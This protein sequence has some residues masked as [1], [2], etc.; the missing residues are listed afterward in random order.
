MPITAPATARPTVP[1][2][3]TTAT[4]VRLLVITSA[5]TSH[6]PTPGRPQ[7]SAWESKHAVCAPRGEILASFN[8]PRHKLRV[9]RAA[10]AAATAA[11]SQV[12]SGASAARGRGVLHA[13]CRRPARAAT[14]FLDRGS[15]TPLWR[16]QLVATP[17]RRCYGCRFWAHGDSGEGPMLRHCVPP[18]RHHPTSPKHS[19]R[20]TRRTS[21]AARSG[22][23]APAAARWRRPGHHPLPRSLPSVSPKARRQPSVVDSPPD[24]S[25]ATHHLSATAAASTVLARRRRRSASRN[26]GRCY[27]G[28]RGDEVPGASAAADAADEAPIGRRDGAT[29]RKEP[30]PGS[31]PE[32][33]FRDGHGARPRLAD[34]Q[35]CAGRSSHL[36]ACR[37]PVLPSLPPPL[38]PPSQLRSPLPPLPMPRRTPAGPR[39]PPPAGTE[40]CR[41]IISHAQTGRMQIS[42]K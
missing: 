38:P 36:H 34:A 30:P 26:E 14:T 23:L 13:A 41:S 8:A 19:R 35:M 18:Q 1:E 40:S 31:A 33:I 5:S 9:F 32:V 11:A 22:P 39:P 12:S 27:R 3:V 17:S 42:A 10:D 2:R 16:Q 4:H 37:G 29:R 15:G 7:N 20:R 6:H 28:H 21:P 24:W 25:A